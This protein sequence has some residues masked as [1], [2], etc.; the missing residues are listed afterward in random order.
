MI[1]LENDNAAA[2]EAIIPQPELIES[3]PEAPALQIP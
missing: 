3:K 2:I 1:K